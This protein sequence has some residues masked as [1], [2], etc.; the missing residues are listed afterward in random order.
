M[1]LHHKLCHAIGGTF[2]LPHAETHA[3][4][5]PHAL[6][7]NAGTVPEAMRGLASALGVENPALKLH[8]LADE[9]GI[10]GGLRSL[11]MSEEDIEQA[12]EVAVMNPY[13]NPRPIER[14]GIRQL[15]AR[16]WAGAP[17]LA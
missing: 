5:L 6:A 10:G 2:G 16:A 7:Y 17:P 15:I 9:L 3:I 13:W 4:I 1:A 8:A 11:G 12:V 14:D